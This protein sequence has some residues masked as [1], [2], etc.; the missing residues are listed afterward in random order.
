MFRRI[1]ETMPWRIMQPGAQPRQVDQNDCKSESPFRS[2]SRQNALLPQKLASKP[3]STAC[4][5]KQSPSIP[6]I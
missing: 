3:E 1:E 5:G 2:A 4:Q 6:C